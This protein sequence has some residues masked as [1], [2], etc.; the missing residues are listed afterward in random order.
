MNASDLKQV[1]LFEDLSDSELKEIAKQVR[2]VRHQ[3]GS[4]VIIRGEG[5]IGF[6]VIL[7]GRAVINT[8][9][10]RTRTLGPGEYFGE[11]S[12]LDQELRSADVT[13]ETELHCAAIPEWGFERFLAEH[14]KVSFRL[15]Q[16]LS[17]RL[18]EAE[19]R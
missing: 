9:D 12:L 15:L 3:P 4:K 17:R 16:T 5:G 11:M 14:P 8:A 18:R 1:R 10:G 13:A 2:E 6:T 19:N 7:A